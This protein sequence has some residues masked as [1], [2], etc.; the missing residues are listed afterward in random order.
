ML[1]RLNLKA[2]KV[3]YRKN[4]GLHINAI[5][6]ANIDEVNTNDEFVCTLVENFILDIIEQHCKLN[7]NI[8]LDTYKEECEENSTQ[9]AVGIRFYSSD[10]RELFEVIREI[11][12]KNNTQFELGFELS[13]VIILTD[14]SFITLEFEEIEELNIDKI[15]EFNG[16]QECYE[17]LKKL[18]TEYNAY[19]TLRELEE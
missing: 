17:S 9:I 3:V 14:D 8:D 13:D 4:G 11:D 19:K 15:K 10:I 2:G 1:K 5:M 12:M 16:T 18:Y 7:G 6:Y